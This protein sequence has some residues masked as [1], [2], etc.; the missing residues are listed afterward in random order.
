M[1][2]LRGTKSWHPKRAAGPD[3]VITCATIRLFTKGKTPRIVHTIK[4]IRDEYP[5]RAL[6]PEPHRGQQT[7]VSL[8]TTN[9]ITLYSNMKRITL[10]IWPVPEEGRWF[11][12]KQ[13]LRRGKWG[14]L[15]GCVGE[16]LTSSR[17]CSHKHSNTQ[18]I[19][20]PCI[21]E[22]NGV[23]I[24][25]LN[26][27]RWKMPLP[28]PSTEHTM[29]CSGLCARRSIFKC[30]KIIIHLWTEDGRWDTTYQLI[31]RKRSD[32]PEWPEPKP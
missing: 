32:V 18:G 5:W 2:L 24:H 13:C 26:T 14:G 19:E 9:K 11:W 6:E 3:H 15:S 29:V 17:G 7:Q 10:N 22:W 21:P 16:S 1:R 23:S 20:L 28:G 30:N 8:H 25:V 4:T 27:R 12:K 31:T